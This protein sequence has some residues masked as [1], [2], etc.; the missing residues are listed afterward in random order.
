MTRPEVTRRLPHPD[1]WVQ[2]IE[3]D[4]LRIE[5]IRGPDRG[6]SLTLSMAVISI[7]SAAENDVQL[8]DASVSRFH[9]RISQTPGGWLLED[10]ESTNGTLV[11]GLRIKQ[12][13]LRPGIQIALGQSTLELLVR[14]EKFYGMPG[15]TRRPPDLVGDSPAMEEVWG[16]VQAA[17]R[18]PTSVLLLG[19]SGT[20]KEVI[21]RALHRE[22][23]RPGPLV[24]FDCGSTSPDLIRSELFGHV[25]G[26]F[27]GAGGPRPGAFRAADQGTI[28][29]D[30]LGDLPLDLQSHLLRVLET[31]EV[32][33]LGSDV[34]HRIDVRLVAATHR[35]LE[36]MVAK[37]TFRSDLY[38]R[39]AVVCIRVPSLRQRL[40][41]V[42][43][44]VRYFSHQLGSRVVFDDEV[45]AAMQAKSWPGNLRELRNTVERLTVLAAGGPVSLRHLE[46]GAA[47]A[48]PAPARTPTAAPKSSS[49]QEVE[50]EQIRQALE[51]AGGNKTHAA[52]ALGIDV[53]TLRRKLNRR[54]P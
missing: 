11:D 30:E 50:D 28:F 10:L 15:K 34:S 47:P 31:R 35:D 9:A 51:S 48:Q 33:P 36:E 29:I 4:S 18:A 7:G 2:V 42:P 23:G 38:Y 26:A 17:A 40:E 16:L 46:L 3:L 21:S 52:R 25:P 19:E 53:S 1:G 54:D 8:E 13:Y 22:S 43:A 14:T 45:L 27:T 6:K 49:L 20:G 41:D 37:G 32:K 24:V 5:V 39:I 12:V 44:L